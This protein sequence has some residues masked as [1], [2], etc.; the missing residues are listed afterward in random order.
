MSS[1]DFN[2]A[3]VDNPKSLTKSDNYWYGLSASTTGIPGHPGTR[4][5]SEREAGEG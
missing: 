3:V 5:S 2:L 4:V 1:K